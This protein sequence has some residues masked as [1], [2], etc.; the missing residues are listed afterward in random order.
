MSPTN[1][2]VSSKGRN[3]NYPLETKGS[4]LAA[5]LRQETNRL[6]AKERRDLFKRGMQIIYGGV[7][8]EEKPGAGH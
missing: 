7:A 2:S 3:F 1:P 5:R 4:R 8:T 6:S